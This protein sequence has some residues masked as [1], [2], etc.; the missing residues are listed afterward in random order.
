MP[1]YE[2]ECDACG[3]AFERI[4][5]FNDDPVSKCPRCA[6]AVRRVISPVGVIFKGSGWYI[7]DSRRHLSG[8]GSATRRLTGD[9][10]GEGTGDGTGDGTS[11]GKGASG[12]TGASK[13]GTPDAGGTGEGTAAD[14]GT[15]AAEV[16]PGAKPAKGG[17]SATAGKTR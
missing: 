1:I 6:G 4:Q 8:S 15:P 12:D 9:G 5:S 17:R 3:Y 2:Y 13:S 7:T 10:K 16:G 11:D 14:A